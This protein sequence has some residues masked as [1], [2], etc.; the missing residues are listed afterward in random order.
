MVQAY[1]STE[2]KMQC[3]KDAHIVMVFG[4]SPTGLATTTPALFG[5]ATDN[6]IY[7]QQHNGALY[8]RLDGLHLHSACQ[9]ALASCKRVPTTLAAD[10]TR[11]C[12][13]SNR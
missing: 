10:G 3:S 5:D 4:L 8:R 7:P 9:M 1:Q 2:Y 12:P 6:V 13:D 11:A